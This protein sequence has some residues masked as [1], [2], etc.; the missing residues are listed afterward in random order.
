MAKKNNPLDDLHDL[1]LDL[2][3]W[4]GPLS[5]ALVF[6]LMRWLV[7]M[8]A[9]EETSSIGAT[10]AK[11]LGGLSHA[12]APFVAGLMLFVWAFAMLKRF[13]NKWSF[14]RQSGTDSIRRLSWQQFEELVSETYRRQ[15]FRVSQL[16]GEGPDGGIDQRIRK[17]GEHALVQCKHWRTQKVGVKIARELLGAVTSERA[18]YG[19]LITSG[20]FTDDAI[21]FGR[22][23][24]LELIDGPK[25]MD[26]LAPLREE[27][28]PSDTER[29]PSCVKC[30][31]K[32]IIRTRR[33]EPDAGKQFWG[34][35]NWPDCNGSRS[36]S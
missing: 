7:P 21:D 29:I 28:P 35:S 8:A 1:F 24:S 9:P 23:N 22:K 26:L 31:A 25:L 18:D 15:G 19:I 34:C 27:L 4:A 2:P 10:M 16:G 12:F 13:I 32:M 30:G 11:S 20:T 3:V 17:E 33:K 36:I 6:V 14:D 5:A